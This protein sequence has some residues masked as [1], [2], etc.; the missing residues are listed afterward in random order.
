MKLGLDGKLAVV[1]GASKGIGLAVTQRFVEEGARVVTGSRSVSA[2]L[3]E[4]VEGGAV[5]AVA[6]DLAEPSG[7]ARLIE[8]AGDR[9]DI[10][11]NNVGFAASRLDGFLGITDEMWE[12]TLD[13]D[14]MAGVRAIR[15]AIP[16]MLA[17]GRGVIVNVGSVNAR[18][19][20]PMVVDY[21]AAKA[22]FNNLAKALS[23]EFGPQNIRVNTVDP[24]PV[25][26]DFW[27]GRDGVAVKLGDASGKSPEQVIA[28]FGSN[29]LTGRFTS[30]GEVAD[31]VM[32]LASDRFANMM[33]AG[34]TID[35]GM[36]PT[37]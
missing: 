22:A 15:A 13:L 30:P 26:T 11:V 17:N 14:F 33:G 29:A 12:H 18:L 21:S 35:G 2:E 19:P 1:T 32:M 28:E 34:V 10:L 27:A 36:V 16:A 3:A 9:L 8:A 25:A 37:L 4:L 6:V 5:E 23:K 31:L 7:P 24:G 20:L